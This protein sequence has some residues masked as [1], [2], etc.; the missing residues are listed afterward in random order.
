MQ[1]FIDISQIRKGRM[2]GEGTEGYV[3]LLLN[4]P[5]HVYKEYDDLKPSQSKSKIL[6][7]SALMDIDNLYKY[8]IPI[9]YMVIDKKSDPNNLLGIIERTDYSKSLS[10][11]TNEQKLI[12][13]YNFK[14]VLEGLNKLHVRHFD[15]RPDNIRHNNN[16]KNLWLS[17]MDSAYVDGIESDYSYEYISHYLHLGGKPNFNA[18]IFIFNFIT[19]ASLTKSSLSFDDKLKYVDT[20]L[21]NR[22]LDTPRINHFCK[23]MFSGKVNQIADHEYL[24]DIIM[25][26][27]INNERDGK[28]AAL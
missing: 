17:D 28:Y 24:I 10:D 1:K 2:I 6:N 12:A 26:H 20:R 25:D 3:Y 11:F 16:P 23:E 8:G 21:R 15:L 9:D 19:Y 13:L 22:N 14:K 27:N 18:V 7:I 5:D 4:D